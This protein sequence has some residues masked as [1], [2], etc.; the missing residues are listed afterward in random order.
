[1]TKC[2]YC[3]EEMREGYLFSSKDG[4]LSFA[5]KIPGVFENAKKAAG[6]IRVTEPKAAHRSNVKA[7]ACEN[8]RK[9]VVEY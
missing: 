5:E 4:A 6:F 1:M 3:G 2:P 7:N 8:C 9:I